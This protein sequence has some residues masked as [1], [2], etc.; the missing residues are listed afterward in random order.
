MEGQS[1]CS[2]ITDFRPSAVQ[3]ATIQPQ[4]RVLKGKP[5][6]PKQNKMQKKCMCIRANKQKYLFQKPFL[7][8][9]FKACFIIKCWKVPL[10]F[11]LVHLSVVLLVLRRILR[12]LLRMEKLVR[13][14]K[15]LLWKQFILHCFNL[16]YIWMWLWW[17]DWFHR[18]PLCNVACPTVVCSVFRTA[19]H[20]TGIVSD[21]ERCACLVLLS[22]S[23][24]VNFHKFKFRLTHL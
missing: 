15:S 22:C 16:K 18:A 9:L 4:S 21:A 2:S 8:F 3:S 7:A 17:C 19:S 5:P 23:D 1:S 6:W 12:D 11:Y 20:L 14:N 24:C 13:H 10:V